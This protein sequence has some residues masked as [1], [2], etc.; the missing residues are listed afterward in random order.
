MLVVVVVVVVLVEVVLVEV[1]LNF[2]YY[3][4]K[5]VFQCIV[6]TMNTQMHTY[7]CQT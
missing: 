6:T 1:V 7:K 4:S 2:D 3:N 5:T